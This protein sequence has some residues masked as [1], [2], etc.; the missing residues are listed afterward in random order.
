M[1]ETEAVTLS[2]DPPDDAGLATNVPLAD[3]MLNAELQ[4]LSSGKSINSKDIGK[5]KNIEGNNI[6]NYN[7]NI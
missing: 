5:S 3:I 2:E 1:N 6:G 4:L 7:D